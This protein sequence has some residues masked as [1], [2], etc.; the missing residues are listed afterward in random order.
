[1]RTPFNLYCRCFT[2][3]DNDAIKALFAWCATYIAI[4]CLSEFGTVWL[5]VIAW[6]YADSENAVKTGKQ[7]SAQAQSGF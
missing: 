3:I 4:K 6:R 1:L 2:F 7:A 5:W